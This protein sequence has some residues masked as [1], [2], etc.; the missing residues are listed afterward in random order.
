MK[1][2]NLQTY[3]TIPVFWHVS[4]NPV[5]NN[6]SLCL[7]VQVEATKLSSDNESIWI[8][9]PFWTCQCNRMIWLEWLH[10]KLLFKMEFNTLLL[11]PMKK[12]LLNQFTYILCILGSVSVA[13][14]NSLTIWYPLYIRF[15]HV[16]WNSLF[17]TKLIH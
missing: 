16:D 14:M 13:F 6:N 17:N 9:N 2:N 8:P 3:A 12:Y 15:F 10:K 1:L 5:E 4:L 7:F 11:R